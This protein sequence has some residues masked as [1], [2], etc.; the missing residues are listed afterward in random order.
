MKQP[1][2]DLRRCTTK[3]IHCD[4]FIGILRYSAVPSVLEGPSAL[5]E[6]HSTIEVYL[7]LSEA[8]HFNPF[9]TVVPFWG[10]NYL[11]FDW[12]VPKTGLRF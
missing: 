11:K 10:T 2:D 1:H 12:F 8:P 9:S 4:S 6:R 5:N 7:T 3:N